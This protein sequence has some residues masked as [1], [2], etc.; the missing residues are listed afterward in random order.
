MLQDACGRRNEPAAAEQRWPL[1][2]AS[3][4]LA[5]GVQLRNDLWPNQELRLD[6]ALPASSHAS[7][8]CLALV[9]EVLCV[10]RCVAFPLPTH[11]FYLILTRAVVQIY[12][13][14]VH[15]LCELPSVEET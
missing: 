10:P 14:L 2:Q 8:M 5:D 13:Y 7:L 12:V 3:T 4:K 6:R 15:H 9:C 1:A 11:T